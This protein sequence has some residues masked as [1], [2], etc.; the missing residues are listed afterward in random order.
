MFITSIKTKKYNTTRY[1]FAARYKLHD[2]DLRTMGWIFTL[3]TIQCYS[4]QFTKYIKHSVGT[5]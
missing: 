2:A 3:H 1:T 5:L 4:L